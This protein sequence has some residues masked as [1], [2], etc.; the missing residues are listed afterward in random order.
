VHA[1]YQ[2]LG[3]DALYAQAANELYTTD[4]RQLNIYD[5]NIGGALYHVERP[6]GRTVYLAQD[7]FWLCKDQC[8][9]G[10]PEG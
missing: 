6:F 7:K 5:G 8:L 2:E 3:A 4:A 10:L 1:A 9:Q